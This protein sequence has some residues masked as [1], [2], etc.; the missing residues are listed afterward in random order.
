MSLRPPQVGT[1][2]CTIADGLKMWISC[3]AFGCR[4]NADVDLVALRDQRGADYRIADFVAPQPVQQVRRQVA[5]AL[6]QGL[7]YLYRRDARLGAS[8]SAKWGIMG[9]QQN[10]TQGVR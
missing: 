3:N 5:A 2:G 1:I 8:K 7:A 6:G 4:N 9:G 10:E